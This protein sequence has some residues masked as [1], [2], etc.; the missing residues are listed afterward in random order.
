M[1][2]ELH[3]KKIKGY[4]EGREL[5]H[6]GNFQQLRELLSSYTEN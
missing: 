2:L 6:N 1:V 5:G 4:T 3:L